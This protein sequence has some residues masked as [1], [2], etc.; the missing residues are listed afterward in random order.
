M[1]STNT[2][3]RLYDSLL[4]FP[5][6]QGLSRTELMQLAGQTKFG[7][8]KMEAQKMVVKEGNPCKEL[9]FLISGTLSVTTYSDDRRYHVE[10][11]LSAPL[12][13][14][15][16]N[17]F[18]AHPQYTSTVTAETDSHFI[19][20]SKDEVL[21][22][23][24]DFL[25][26]RI[27]LLNMLATQS[28]RRGRWPWRKAPADLRQCI[29]RFFLNHSTYPAGPKM[30]HILMNQ[31]ALEVNDSRLDVSRVLNKM[32]EE[33]LIHLYRGRIGIPSLERLIM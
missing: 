10:E 31:I 6:F 25:I 28:Q 5:L 7:F 8:V 17:I 24:D 23:L 11:K 21:R 20:L 2:D 9:F 19:T 15:P 4:R 26:I 14:Q 27:N 12:L 13:L 1:S 16:E 29:I 18:G 30:F 32:Q 3:L 22:L 33:G